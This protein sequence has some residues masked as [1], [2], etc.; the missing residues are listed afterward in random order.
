MVRYI[1]IETGASPEVACHFAHPGRQRE[2]D[3]GRNVRLS[4]PSGPGVPQGAA[5]VSSSRCARC[6]SVSTVPF[7]H[8]VRCLRP[9]CVGSY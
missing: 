4:L 6:C 9:S 7:E 1:H 2:T 5:S 8:E 3:P